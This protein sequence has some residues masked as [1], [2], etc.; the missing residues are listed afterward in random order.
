MGPTLAVRPYFTTVTAI[1]APPASV[2]I[3]IIKAKVGQTHIADH[4]QDPP[5]NDR[6]AGEPPGSASRVDY[7]WWGNRRTVQTVQRLLLLG[8]RDRA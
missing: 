4:R 7:A 1:A 8:R 2:I 6:A 3:T 5:A